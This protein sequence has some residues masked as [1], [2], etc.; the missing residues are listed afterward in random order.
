MKG[1][2]I[3][4]VGLTTRRLGGLTV[5]EEFRLFQPFREMRHVERIEI[6][7]SWSPNLDVGHQVETDQRLMIER[8]DQVVVDHPPWTFEW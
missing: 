6:V 3:L 4:R 7:T 1:L 2:K 5:D 8:V